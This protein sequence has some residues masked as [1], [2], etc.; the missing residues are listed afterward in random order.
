[1][2]DNLRYED[3][4]VGGEIPSL[5]KT[6][7]TRQLVRYAAAA[8]DFN[9][10]HY[11]KDFA[12]STGLDGVIVHGALKSAF[13][14][15]LLTDWLGDSGVLQKLIVQYRAIDVPGD[16]LICHGQVKGKHIKHGVGFLDCTIWIE[17]SKG[18]CTTVGSAT[19]KLNN[20]VGAG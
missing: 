7:T 12:Q 4:K 5:I 3:V 16:I 18:V 14:G 6:P 8:G 13:L 11:D 9:E 2:H 20:M 17:N 10:I 15:Q 1:M 19:V